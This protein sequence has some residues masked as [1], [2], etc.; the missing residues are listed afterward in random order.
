MPCRQSDSLIQNG[1]FE[2]GGTPGWT[3][4]GW[5]VYI[6]AGTAPIVLRHDV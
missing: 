6:P 3:T 1:S 2:Q 5:E 4:N